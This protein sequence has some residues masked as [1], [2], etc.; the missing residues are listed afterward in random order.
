MNA[1]RVLTR[2]TERIVRSCDP[3][4]VVLFGSFAKGQQDVHSDID[5]LVVGR[6]P[7]SPHVRGRELRESLREFPIR[8]DLLLMTSNELSRQMEEP[9]GFL[10]SVL[11]TSRT[12]Y[13]KLDFS[14]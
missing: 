9:F 10:A 14:C 4:A 13:G 2:I 8:I 7:E 5:I 1:E 3:Q 11:G 6:F 12:L